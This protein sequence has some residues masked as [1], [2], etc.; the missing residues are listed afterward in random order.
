[1]YHEVQNKIGLRV[2]ET[3]LKAVCLTKQCS[4]NWSDAQ[5]LS[6][7][8]SPELCIKDPVLT[9]S[10]NLVFQIKNSCLTLLDSKVVSKLNCH[11]TEMKM[12]KLIKT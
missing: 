6:L 1:M 5:C 10:V 9:R 8:M 2:F 7:G 12:T 4:L 3:Q 11:K